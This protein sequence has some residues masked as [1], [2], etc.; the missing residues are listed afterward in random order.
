[1][2]YGENTNIT[3]HYAEGKNLAD[4]IV[5]IKLKTRKD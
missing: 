1:M 3:I 5:K 4:D 2:E